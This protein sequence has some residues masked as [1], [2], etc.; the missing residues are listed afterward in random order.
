[1]GNPFENQVVSAR[2][3]AEALADEGRLG[4]AAGAYEDLA[5]AWI[6][7]C[8]SVLSAYARK[9]RLDEAEKAKKLAAI[10]R[11]KAGKVTLKT[12]SD[13][14][15]HPEGDNN[16]RDDNGE[17]GGDAGV[18]DDPGPCESLDELLGQL[19]A[20]VGL[21]GVKREVRLN[22]ELLDFHKMRS[23]NGLANPELSH[24]LVF[25]GNPGTGKT[26]VA[27]LI[28]K[29]YRSM[30]LLKKGQLIETDRE[31]LIAEHI[32]GTAVKTKAVIKKALGGVLFIDEAYE[33]GKKGQ[34]GND[35]GPEAIA[36]LLKAMEDHRDNL[37]VIVAGY[38]DLMEYMIKHT[39]PGLPSRFRTT[40]HFDNYS[41]EEL[42]LIFQR[43]AEKQDHV[44]TDECIQA[45]RSHYEKILENPPPDFANARDARNLFED[46]HQNMAHRVALIKSST[47]NPT[48]EQLKTMLPEDLPFHD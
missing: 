45:V 46:A 11:A 12:S 7:S 27:R 25:T 37:V 28:A 41:A 17:D 47:Q 14:P 10:Y 2:K 3:K 38:P 29:L 23:E 15:R 22:M 42:V 8:A 32:G 24:H 13:D 40:I 34:A 1:M 18:D 43:Y 48:L 35:F 9:D 21:E 33:L 20:L 36:T 16:D 4:E 26:T 6:A 39:N 44:P 30:G 19:D 5:R 31:G